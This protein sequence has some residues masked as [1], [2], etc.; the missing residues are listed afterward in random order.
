MT[1]YNHFKNNKLFNYFS[2]VNEEDYLDS[3]NECVITNTTVYYLTRKVSTKSVLKGYLKSTLTFKTN[4]LF[5]KDTYSDFETNQIDL[6]N[7]RSI[8][9]EH[10]KN[11]VEGVLSLRKKEEDQRKNEESERIQ[12]QKYLQELEKKEE[13]LRKEK[14]EILE[15][16]QYRILNDLDT[17]GN[18]VIDVIEGSDDFMKLFRKHQTIIKEF[19]NNYINHLVKVS[20]FLKAK[21]KNIQEVFNEIKRSQNESQ[22]EENVG[23]LKN[24]IHTYEQ[25]LF[26]SLTMIVSIVEGDSITVN[27]I[28][29]EFDK[30]KI[31]QSDYQKEVSQKLSDIGDG[32]NQLLLSL[33]SMEKN[34]VNGLNQ[35]SYVT[36]EGFSD[37]SD[38][39]SQELKSIGSSIDTNNL[40]T[41]IQTYQLYKLNTQT[42]GLN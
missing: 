19:D 37:L 11:F 25:L 22:L 24:Q 39:I 20:N 2:H 42:K 7:F 33:N 5:E 17:D 4:T 1:P 40:L 36:Q 13:S 12:R 6:S 34:I 9:E 35:L 32:L 31:F 28:Y 21:R 30:L 18:G 10:I 26:H 41:G 38:S 16:K 8:N 27:E 23:L 29:E 3:N 14:Q 15:I